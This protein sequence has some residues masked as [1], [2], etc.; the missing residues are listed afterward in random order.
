MKI[1][2]YKKMMVEEVL[3]K[4][5]SPEMMEKHSKYIKNIAQGMTSIE[6]QAITL[7]AT[8][9][10]KGEAPSKKEPSEG[11][12]LN[13][14]EMALFKSFKQIIRARKDEGKNYKP[15]AKMNNYNYCKIDHFIA[16]CAYSKDDDKEEKEREEG[17]KN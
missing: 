9:E 11:L 3:G 5:L 7:K 17:K 6:P 2:R 14:E 1:S 13:E 8:N 10:K 12:G 4:F 15:L 16:N